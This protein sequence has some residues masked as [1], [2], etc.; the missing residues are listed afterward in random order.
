MT[1]ASNLTNTMSSSGVPR[2]CMAHMHMQRISY[3]T[4][5][6][7]R[8]FA[9]QTMPLVPFTCRKRL[10]LQFAQHYGLQADTVLCC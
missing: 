2:V 3:I 8:H 5:E 7:L 4:A 1:S 6:H 10:P 9:Y